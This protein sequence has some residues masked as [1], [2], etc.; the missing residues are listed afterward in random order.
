MSFVDFV[1]NKFIWIVMSVGN[2]TVEI[3]EV[4]QN[5]ANSNCMIYPH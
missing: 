5:W 2:L 4:K 3:P 1:A